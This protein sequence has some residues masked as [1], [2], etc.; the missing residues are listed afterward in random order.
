MALAVSAGVAVAAAALAD[1]QEAHANV[2]YMASAAH[3]RTL[4]VRASMMHP[5]ART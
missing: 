3:W 2:L 1:R 5:A 4:A